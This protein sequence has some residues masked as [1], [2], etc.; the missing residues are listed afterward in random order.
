VAVGGGGVNTC[1]YASK[2][3]GFYLY[4]NLDDEDMQVVSVI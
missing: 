1:K 2:I 4:G 3:W